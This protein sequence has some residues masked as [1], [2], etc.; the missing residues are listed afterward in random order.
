MKVNV[1]FDLDVDVKKWAGSDADTITTGQ[2]ADEVRG[3]VEQ[4]TKELYAQRGWL[5]TGETADATA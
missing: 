3:H 4:C 2:V 1:S 5:D